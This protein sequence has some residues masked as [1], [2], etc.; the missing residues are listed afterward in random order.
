MDPELKTYL[1]QMERRLRDHAEAIETKLLSE[2][3][4]WARTA[5]ARYRQSSAQVNGVDERLGIL[6]SRVTDLESGHK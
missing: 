4:K 3:W 2:F 1:E 5:D 6:E